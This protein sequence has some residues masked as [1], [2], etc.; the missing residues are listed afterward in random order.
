METSLLGNAP[1]GG[2]FYAP[3]SN[4]RARA[5]SSP[6]NSLIASSNTHLSAADGLNSMSAMAVFYNAAFLAS[7]SAGTLIP[8]LLRKPATLRRPIPE[9]HDRQMDRAD[10]SGW[11]R[12]TGNEK[13]LLRAL[14]GGSLAVEQATA[15]VAG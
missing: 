2:E 3:F 10:W 4:S 6:I 14:P 15:K 12:E 9:I 5:S 13:D 7:K 8:Q 11:L 1:R